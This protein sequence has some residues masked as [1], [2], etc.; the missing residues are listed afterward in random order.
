M[1]V[2]PSQQV[3]ASRT[4]L[5]GIYMGDAMS[6]K[7][8]CA[9]T[10]P[11]PLV[12]CFDPDTST[13]RSMPGVWVVELSTWSELETAVMPYVRNRALGKFIVDRAGFPM[14]EPEI[15]T[16]VV[17]TISIGATKLVQELQGTKDRLTQA[18]YG[19]LLNKLTGITM[20]LIE[21]TKES[22]VNKALPTYNVILTTHLRTVTN[23][24]GAIEGI[25][26]AI[27]GQFQDVLP[28]L[29]G[30]AFLC[31][32]GV[33]TEF[34]S[35]KAT[36]VESFNVRTVP[37]NSRYICGDRIGGKNGLNR[38]PTKVGGTYQELCEA[39]GRQP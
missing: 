5:S 28:R 1:N 34:K 4:K 11:K 21:T 2:Y 37:P 6:G 31:E 25:R 18:D 13:V 3:T 29:G 14:E 39:W 16:I 35:G 30:F 12:L 26:P 15:E 27:P 23:D 36:E 33:T 19:L 20:Q 17:D 10:W 22:A 32:H 24:Q 38:L 7:S 8:H 9:A